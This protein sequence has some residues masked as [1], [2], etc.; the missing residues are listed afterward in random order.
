MNNEVLIK[1]EHVSIP[2]HRDCRGECLGLI[3]QY[4]MGIF[5]LYT[6]VNRITRL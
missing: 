3:V 1:A 5:V 4:G 2:M 6:D